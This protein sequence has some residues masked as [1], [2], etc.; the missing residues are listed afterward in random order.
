MFAITVIAGKQYT[1]SPG[2]TLEVDRIEG[3]TG[4]SVT[5]D[6]VLLVDDGKKT[7]V[8]TPTVKG[9]TVKAKI[10]SQVQG[11][12]VRVRRYKSKVRYRKSIGFRPQITKLEIVAIG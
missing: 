2:D 11:E 9:A 12:K 1:V 6:R 4:D 10:V 7:S 5:F 3:K 8:G